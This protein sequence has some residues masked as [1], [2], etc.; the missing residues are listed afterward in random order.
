MISIVEAIIFQLSDIKLPLKVMPESRCTQC[1]LIVQHNFQNVIVCVDLFKA[2][3]S[4]IHR[5][6]GWSVL[7]SQPAYH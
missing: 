3:T 7:T 4:Y 6:M 5:G 1:E 2:Y